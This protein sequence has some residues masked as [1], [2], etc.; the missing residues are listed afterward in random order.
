MKTVTDYFTENY[1]GV[2]AEGVYCLATGRLIG[3]NY[4]ALEL[5]ESMLQSGMHP[6]EVA[7]DLAIRLFASMRPGLF[8]NKMTLKTVAQL[9]ESRPIETLAWLLNR[10]LNPP[11]FKG[12]VFAINHDR[13]MTYQW[14]Q[15]LES[16]IRNSLID[17]LIALDARLNLNQQLPD[18][19]FDSLLMDG[20]PAIHRWI[21]SAEKKAA[22]REKAMEQ[23]TRWYRDGN[24]MSKAAAVQTFAKNKPESPAKAQATEKRK[25]QAM[26]D[27]L[28]AALMSGTATPDSRS[29]DTPKAQ[30]VQPKRVG[31]GL[32]F[33]QKKV[34]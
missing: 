8:W 4:E 34:S 20:A 21:D 28:L 12:D 5:G 9:Q 33:L 18:F 17:R 16:E 7:D 26:M 3:T 11:Q 15:G 25:T 1:P 23:Q 10:L 22:Q 27:N 14:C 2:S 6:E 29:V 19:T 32:A 24:T 30:P 13:I 31:T